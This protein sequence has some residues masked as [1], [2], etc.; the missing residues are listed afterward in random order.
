MKFRTLHIIA[1]SLIDSYEVNSIYDQRRKDNAQRRLD[2]DIALYNAEGRSSDGILGVV[3]E[4]LSHP[5]AS[6]ITDLRSKGKADGFYKVG[7]R[8][9]PYEHKTDGGRLG[10]L[11]ACKRLDNMLV[12]YRYIKVIPASKRKPERVYFTKRV[13]IAED[14]IET[15]EATP[16]AIKWT[17]HKGLG[18]VDRE[19]A[20]QMTLRV[21]EAVK[22]LGE[23]FDRNKVQF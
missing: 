22:D 18:H 1:Q 15:L 20:I 2:A 11:Y 5:S 17:S 6:T 23:E 3:D 4:I 21:Y 14:F 10:G 16:G 13:C 19:P 8:Y 12:V 9:V 7:G